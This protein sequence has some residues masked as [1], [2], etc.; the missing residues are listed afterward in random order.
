M[1]LNWGIL[2]AGNIARKFADGV[3]AS[4]TGR[5]VAVGARDRERAAELAGLHQ[6]RAFGSYEEVLADPEVDA[7]YIATPHHLHAE[8][9]IKAAEAGKGVLCEKPFTMTAHEAESA[10]TAVRRCGVF[11]MEAFMYRCSPQT[12]KVVQ[13]LDE[14]AI[15]PVRAVSSTFCFKSRPDWDN[16]RTDGRLGGGGLLD[17]GSYCTSFARLAVGE[18]PLEVAYTADLAR[19]YDAYGAGTLRFPGGAIASIASGIQLTMRNDAVVYGEE[20][21]LVVE[22]PWKSY[23]GSKVTLVREGRETEDFGL[24]CT[25]DELYAY[26]ADAVAAHFDQKECPYMSLDDTLGNMRCL[27]RLRAACGYRFPDEA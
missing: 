11:F 18:E 25:G 5:L 1:A 14:G 7:V 22:E 19:G 12:R 16:F 24:G 15:G 23:P 10:L 4:S 13:L 2:T 8:W 26:E 17:V 27:D 3:A 6:A 20:G 21:M 9:T